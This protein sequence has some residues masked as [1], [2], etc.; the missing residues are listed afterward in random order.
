[1]KMNKIVLPLVLALTATLAVTG[2]THNYNGKVTKLPDHQ[3]PA[4]AGTSGPGDTLPPAPAIDTTQQMPVAGTGPDTKTGGGE[5]P[6]SWRP[7]DMNQ[8]RDKLAA[9]TVHFKFDSAVVQDSEQ[10]EVASVGQALTAD[11]NAKL[12]IEGNCDERGTEEYNRSLGERRAL[13]LREALAKDGVDPMRIR[14]ISYGKDKPADTGHDESAWAKNRRG[15]FIYCT[16]KTP[17]PGTADLT[18]N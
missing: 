2:C 10:A 11:A 16:P 5:L 1:M 15:D 3:A 4:V 13:A 17:A 7:E 12:L 6:E 18:T 14:T 8:D 9:Y